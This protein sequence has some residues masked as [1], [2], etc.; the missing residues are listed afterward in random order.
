ME[1]YNWDFTENEIKLIKDKLKIIELD[2]DEGIS[3]SKLFKKV[4][5]TNY[6]TALLVKY[7]YSVSRKA[8]NEKINSNLNYFK[9][10][11]KTICEDMSCYEGSSLYYKSCIEIRLSVP[12]ERNMEFIDGMVGFVFIN[13]L[14]E[15]GEISEID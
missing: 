13:L 10:I 3:L 6:E 2:D 14:S 1:H 5:R 8:N 7:S 4:N 12:I 15:E 11:M 9:N